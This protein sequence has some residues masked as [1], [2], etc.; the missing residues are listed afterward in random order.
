MVWSTNE[1]QDLNNKN[2][3][4]KFSAHN[5]CLEKPSSGDAQNDII[6]IQL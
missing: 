3:D 1:S 2:I 4:I 5:G 6:I